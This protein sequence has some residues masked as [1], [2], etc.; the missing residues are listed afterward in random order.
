M[1]VP[2]DNSHPILKKWESEGT[3]LNVRLGSDWFSLKFESRIIGVSEHILVLA[4]E[5]TEL[6][7]LLEGA[8]FK[9]S[10]PR[11]MT[12]AVPKEWKESVEAAFDSMLVISLS[13]G[14]ECILAAYR[15][16]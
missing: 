1:N 8:S 6:T 9:Y 15:S 14:M 5:S 3:R 16:D 11:E 10:E 2:V 13:S 7:L 12:S 4:W